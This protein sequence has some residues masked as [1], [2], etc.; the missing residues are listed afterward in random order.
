[1]PVTINPATEEVITEY[2]DMPYPELEAILKATS[3]EAAAWSEFPIEDRA[4]HM[5]KAADVLDRR[6]E[7]LALLMTRE[8]GKPIKEAR[9]E[10]E[11]CAMVCRY[12]AEH[13][14]RF[15][16][17]ETIEG[18]VKSYVTFHPL[19]VVLAIMPWN[20]PLWQVFR[21]VAPGLI[22]G[23]GGILKHSPNVTGCALAIESVLQEAGFPK[24]LF[25]TIIASTD[26]IKQVIESDYIQAVTL[27]GSE[28]AGVA[29]ATAAGGSL[30]KCVLELGGSDPYLILEDADLDLAVDKC[31]AG[32]LL[33]AGQSCIA[34][35]RL[36]TIASIHDNFVEELMR[37]VASYTVGD[38]E[39]EKT[40]IGPMARSDLRES[41]HK[42]VTASVSGGAELKLGG[43]IPNKTGFYYPITILDHV[44]A[45]TPAYDEELFGPVITIIE[46]KD[47]ADAIRIANDTRF[48]LGSAVFT[49]DL[50][51]GERIAK[52]LESGLTFINDFVKSDANHPFGGVKKSGYGRELSQ[53]GI[54]EFVN[55]K[56]VMVMG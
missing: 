3:K 18:D 37:K 30:K 5:F 9:G 44:K 48:G 26:D 40:D 2:E 25:R 36:I 16:E 56:T 1:M 53:Y 21:F 19:G 41:L 10:V 54:R 50:A 39:D 33:N 14:P 28:R 32:R 20:F 12:F 55:I 46:A 13:G 4:Q 45:D 52:Q 11:K 47:E 24:N 35:K 8:M 38:P 29:V 34:A 27:T 23:N 31:V 15:L 7:K 42:Q 22:A 49:Q 6:K 43:T 17:D 51:R